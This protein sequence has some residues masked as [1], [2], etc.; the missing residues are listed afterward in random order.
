[1]DGDCLIVDDKFLVCVDC[2]VGDSLIV[3]DK[4]LVCVDCLDV[5]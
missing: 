2:L 3:D 5:D 4:F 1:M